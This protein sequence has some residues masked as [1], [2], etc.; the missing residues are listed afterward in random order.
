MQA[1]GREITLEFVA[2]YI[3]LLGKTPKYANV[4]RFCVDHHDTWKST[5]TQRLCR[6]VLEEDAKGAPGGWAY[7]DFLMTGGAG[8]ATASHCPGMTDDEYRTEFALWTLYQSPLIVDTDIRNMTDVM[9]QTLLNEDIIRLH[10]STITPPGKLLGRDW[11]C[12]VPGTSTRHGPCGSL[13]GRRANSNGSSWFVAL[14]NEDGKVEQRLSLSFSLL[15]WPNNATALAED[16][17]KSS[18]ED[19][20]TASRATGG[21]LR[22]MVP[23][24]GTALVKLNLIR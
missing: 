1:T 17:W 18:V 10:Q 16:L 2:G 9:R 7:N 20:A 19:K 14:V 6:A 23:P 3:F 11:S 8:C 21:M 24:H 13:Y 22:R 4:W 12:A 15:G 5:E